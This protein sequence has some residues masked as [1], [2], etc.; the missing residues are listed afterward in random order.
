MVL[1]GKHNYFDRFRYI[2]SDPLNE[3]IKRD[4]NSGEVIDGYLI[5]HNGLKIIPNSYYDN[6]SDILRLNGG[7][8]EPQEEYVFNEIIENLNSK[9]PLMIEL[10]AY[11]GFY[12]M[13]FLQKNTEGVSFLVEPYE[14]FINIGKNHFEINGM[15]GNFIQDFVGKNNFMIDSFV[16]NN[17]LSKINIVHCDIQGHEYEMLL[18]SLDSIKNK[19]IDYFFI[20]TH[21]QN[22]HN[23]C[24]DFL[25]S[26]DYKIIGSADFDNETFC[27]DG[28]LIATSIENHKVFNLG[29]KSE[30]ELISEDYLDKIINKK[31]I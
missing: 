9:T 29:N 22:L 1:M 4:K 6:F 12:S 5:M 10:G 30:M 23:I 24:K 11:W 15:V 16:K 8:H 17:S 3:K 28:V 19:I 20:S 25:Q 31:I 14:D 27:H 21:S 7:V 26:N 2:L 18:G 13:S